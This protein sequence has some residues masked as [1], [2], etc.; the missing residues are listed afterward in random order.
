MYL[1]I[2]GIILSGGKSTR[3]GENK[4]FMKLGDKLVIDRVIELM[5]SLF[6]E[7]IIITNDPKL[8]TYTKLEIFEDIYK[9]VG[10]VAGIHSG[11]THSKTVKNF[12]ISCDIPL[13]NAEMIGSIIK[14]SAGFDIT[15][16]KAD[17]FIQQLCGMYLK[18]TA[19]V[20]E[21]IIDTDKQQ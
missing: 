5:R 2:T 20:I 6:K 15:V 9:E 13:M 14:R 21:N 17:G 7:V 8:Y 3:M 1:D 11:L 16:A 18:S 4:S 19:T 10:P 12:V